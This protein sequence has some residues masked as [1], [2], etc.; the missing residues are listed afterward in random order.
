[1][2]LGSDIAHAHC[3][4]QTCDCSRS[5]PVWLLQNM[6]SSYE[7]EWSA[8]T[9]IQ[10]QTG[11]GGP[12]L[13]VAFSIVRGLGAPERDSL[14]AQAQSFRKCVTGVW[15]LARVAGALGRTTKGQLP[16]PSFS[17]WGK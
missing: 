15:H 17:C 5:T 11:T 10:H 4:E 8:D 13:W 6:L 3:A 1:M 7:G 16:V 9:G 12:L 2:S 14:S